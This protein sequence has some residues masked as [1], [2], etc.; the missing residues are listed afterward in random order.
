MVPRFMKEG[1]NLGVVIIG[2]TIGG[3]RTRKLTERLVGVR[4]G[5]SD[6]IKDGRAG[7]AVDSS[8]MSLE[9]LSEN[10]RW[11]LSRSASALPGSL[12]NQVNHLQCDI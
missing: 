4:C 5:A 7:F 6:L 3:Q 1:Q 11:S 8:S 10:A 12:L 9:R 2:Q